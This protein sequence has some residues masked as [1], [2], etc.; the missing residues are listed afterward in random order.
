[1]LYHR[2]DQTGIGLENGAR[3]PCDLD[4]ADIPDGAEA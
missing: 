4:S 3:L 1:M 2:A